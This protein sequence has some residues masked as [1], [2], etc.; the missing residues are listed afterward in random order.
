MPAIGK[1][2]TLPALLLVSPRAERLAAN[3]S[4]E[5]RRA[6]VVQWIGYDLAEVAM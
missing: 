4:P 5:P 3:C 2:G 6:P 1:C